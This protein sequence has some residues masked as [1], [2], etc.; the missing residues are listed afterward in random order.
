MSGK[1]CKDRTRA[2]GQLS[3]VARTAED[4]QVQRGVGWLLRRAVPRGK[5]ARSQR[6]PAIDDKG[7]IRRLAVA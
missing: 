5:G 3:P 6:R 7:E 4:P 1:L 2:I